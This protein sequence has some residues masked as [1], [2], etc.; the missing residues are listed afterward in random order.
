LSCVLFLGSG[1]IEASEDLVHLAFEVEN[2]DNCIFKLKHS[3]IPK[4]EGP[5]KTSN[6]SRF[7]FTKDPDKCEIELMQYSK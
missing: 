4:T 1:K 2:L 3:R 6:G 7:I 5:I